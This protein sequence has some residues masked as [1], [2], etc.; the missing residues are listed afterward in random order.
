M[1]DLLDSVQSSDV[2]QRVDA[3]RQTTVEAE[4]LVV[5][6]GGEGEVVEHICKV[7]PDVGIAVL[8]QALVVETVDLGDLPRLVISSQDGDALGV[9]NLEG[10]EQGDGLDG[11]VA[12]VDVVTWQTSSRQ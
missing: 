2:I 3:G 5:D 6:E 7:L 1:R 10:N 12:S 11:V 4:D 8:A 9:S